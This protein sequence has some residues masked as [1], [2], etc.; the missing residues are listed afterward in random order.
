MSNT[1]LLIRIAMALEK[2]DADRLKRVTEAIENVAAAAVT[3]Q[4]P[5]PWNDA[6]VPVRIKNRQWYCKGGK[7]VT[8]ESFIALGRSTCFYH[9]RSVW[10]PGVGPKSIEQLDPIFDEYGF[11]KRWQDS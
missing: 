3:T 10:G 4:T 11:G 9:S 7:P 5:F 8:F 1:E 2:L 6:R